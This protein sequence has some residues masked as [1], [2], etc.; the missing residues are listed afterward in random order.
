MKITFPNLTA[1]E[2]VKKYHNKLGSG[3]LLYNT[4][5]YKD[6][7]FYTK[8][9]CREG[10][11][12][13]ITDLK[14]TFGKTWDE[15][16]KMGEMLNFAEL[17]WCVVKIP[18][19]LKD[20]YSWTKS[21]TSGGEFVDAGSFDVDGGDVHGLGPGASSS[22]IGCAFSAGKL[23]TSNIDTL[24]SD[25]PSRAGVLEDAIKVVK[26]NGYKVYKEI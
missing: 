16:D 1:E 14:P 10:T 3:K 11:R 5:W 23:G 4:D 6:E 7:P 19:F 24:S 13:I 20:E 8:E 2:I 17:L 12:E 25:S 21:C 22:D 18:G 26:E 15:C 9:K